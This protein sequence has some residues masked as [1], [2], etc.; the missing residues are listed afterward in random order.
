M[1][2]SDLAFCSHGN[3]WI[4]QIGRRSRRPAQMELGYSP[5]HRTNCMGASCS[6]KLHPWK[7]FTLRKENRRQKANLDWGQDHS[8]CFT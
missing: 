1:K 8:V 3:E 4:S 6:G 2:P 5:K 7:A